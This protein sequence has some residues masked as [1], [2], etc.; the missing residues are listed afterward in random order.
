MWA[1]TWRKSVRQRQDCTISFALYKYSSPLYS[2]KFYGNTLWYYLRM[3]FPYSY[4][5]R[6]TCLIQL[7]IINIP[8]SYFLKR[9][10]LGRQ[11]SQSNWQKQNAHTDYINTTTQ[12][13]SYLMM[14]FP[15]EN[16]RA[17]P[18]GSLKFI[19]I[20]NTLSI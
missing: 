1:Y 20:G 6:Y 9:E 8:H 3:I 12:F 15:C 11:I 19:K 10:R 5:Y 13:W 14:I 16:K 17:K 2:R 7:W 4:K 18:L